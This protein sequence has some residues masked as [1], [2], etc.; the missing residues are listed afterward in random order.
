MGKDDFKNGS[1]K[2]A[3]FTRKNETFALNVEV[4]NHKFRIEGVMFVERQKCDRFL[5]TISIPHPKFETFFNWQSNPAPIGTDE[6]SVIVVHKTSM[7]KIF[8]TDDRGKYN[9]EINFKVSEKRPHQDN[10]IN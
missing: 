2:P 5:T 1:W 4:A 8:T 3:I 7:T 10:N 9:F 6:E